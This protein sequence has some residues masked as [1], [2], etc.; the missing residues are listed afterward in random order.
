MVRKSSGNTTA[1]RSSRLGMARSQRLL[2]KARTHRIFDDVLPFL[3]VTFVSS[4]VAHPRNDVARSGRAPDS[5]NVG[6][7]RLRK[8]LPIF[9]RTGGTTAV[10]SQ[11]CYL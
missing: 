2:H 5:A 4:A 7:V 6:T 3:I 1:A 10:S 11:I 8:I 9:E